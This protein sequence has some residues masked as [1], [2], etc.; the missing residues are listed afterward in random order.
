MQEKRNVGVKE[1]ERLERRGDGERKK[2]TG[3]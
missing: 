1:G 2:E 3:Q